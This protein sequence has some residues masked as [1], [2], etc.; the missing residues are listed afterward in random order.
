[1]RTPIIL[2]AAM[3]AAAALSGCSTI[4]GK[5]ASVTAAAPIACQSLAT[6]GSDVSAIAKLIAAANPNSAKAQSIAASTAKG[7]S[8]TNADCNVL[9]ALAPTVN[10]AVQAG[11]A[12]GSSLTL[13]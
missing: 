9:A 8:V 2:G 11:A 10:G 1:M 7:V 4:T 12:A 13:K 3:F 5:S 6:L